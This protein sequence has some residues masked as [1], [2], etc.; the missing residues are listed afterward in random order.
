MKRSD[1]TEGYLQWQQ[2]IS[3][4]TEQRRDLFQGY[5]R[6]KIRALK[7]TGAFEAEDAVSE[8]IMRALKRDASRSFPTDEGC[9]VAWLLKA[10]YFICLEE[11]RRCW[12]EARSP[13][14]IELAMD[15]YHLSRIGEEH[16]GAVSAGVNSFI[17]SLSSPDATLLQLSLSTALRPPE[18]GERLGL[19]AAAVRQR[20]SRLLRRLRAFLGERGVEL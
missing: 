4:L 5:A 6:L 9:V 10:I 11:G 13:E 1:D 18:I 3:R 20:R 8:A 19:S 17:A 15:C 16:E 7:I 12:A 2:Q 14:Q